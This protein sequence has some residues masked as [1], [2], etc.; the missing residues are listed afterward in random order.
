MDDEDDDDENSTATK[1][2]TFK[3]SKF[4]VLT[5]QIKI[6]INLRLNKIFKTVDIKS[7]LNCFCFINKLKLLK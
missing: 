1:D 6:L 7:Y 3:I 4:Y 2:K 5:I